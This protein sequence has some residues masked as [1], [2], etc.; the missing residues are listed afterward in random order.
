MDTA[1]FVIVA[2]HLD[3][4]KSEWEVSGLS[5]VINLY[6]IPDIQV[7]IQREKNCFFILDIIDLFQS[8]LNE[9][10][11]LIQCI[12]SL[13]IVDPEFFCP[14]CVILLSVVIPIFLPSKLATDQDISSLEL[15]YKTHLS[16]S[17]YM[18]FKT[19][20]KFLAFLR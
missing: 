14:V 8:V 1:S 5:A 20:K 7:I 13:G 15:F 16:F 4:Y 2:P 10:P 3:Y 19:G 9:V 11:S 6:T 17:K 12:L 18:I